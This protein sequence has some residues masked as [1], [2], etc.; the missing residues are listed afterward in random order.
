MK[1]I[2]IRPV[3]NGFIVKVGCQELVFP[4]MEMI[5]KELIRY[6]VNPDTVEK[7]YLERAVNKMQGGGA[8]GY[9]EPT[10]NRTRDYD[11]SGLNQVDSGVTL[12]GGLGR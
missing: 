12:G 1:E 9:G 2:T 10:E 4:S 11:G 6:Q 7:E 8:I 5:T 3:L